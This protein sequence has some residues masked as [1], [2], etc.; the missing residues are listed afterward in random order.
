MK[1]ILFLIFIELF[2]REIFITFYHEI[3]KIKNINNK[4]KLYVPNEIY[5][6]IDN[7]TSLFIKNINQILENSFINKI[8]KFYMDNN[9]KDLN[10]NLNICNINTLFKFKKLIKIYFIF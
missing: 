7:D 6:I 10:E 3:N 9:F 4:Y 2:N 1:Y 5:K 8:Q